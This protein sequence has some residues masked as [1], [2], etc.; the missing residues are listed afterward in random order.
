[1]DDWLKVIAT[2]ARWLNVLGLR[3]KALFRWTRAGQA[4]ISHWLMV[5]F[6]AHHTHGP[7]IK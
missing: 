5:L 3:S 7:G 4:R 2:A 1:L 6:I